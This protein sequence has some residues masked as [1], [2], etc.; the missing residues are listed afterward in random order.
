MKFDINVQKKRVN[1]QI[2]KFLIYTKNQFKGMKPS[3]KDK[4]TLTCFPYI[5]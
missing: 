4:E 2:Q 5:L 1:I 3:F